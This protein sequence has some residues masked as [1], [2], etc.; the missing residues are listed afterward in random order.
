VTPIYDDIRDAIESSD[1]TRYRIAKQTGI[2]ESQLSL[3]MAGKK[4]LSVEALETLADCL[5]MEITTRRKRKKT[6]R[7]DQK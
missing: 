5:G 6:S 2:G 3:F 1:M 4:G 7:K